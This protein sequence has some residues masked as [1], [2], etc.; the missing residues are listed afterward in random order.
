MANH[1]T[2][3]PT[4]AL[5]VLRRG[6]GSPVR[7]ASFAAPRR[8]GVV[9]LFQAGRVLSEA[10]AADTAG[11]RFRL[12]HLAALRG[13]AAVFAERTSATGRRRPM[14]AWV[15]LDVG[16]SGTVGLGGVLLGRGG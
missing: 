6:D 1:L 16:G 14:N 11:E 12:A 13:A 9:L 10:A 8:S 5:P 2:A 15:L 3:V 4:A 7:L